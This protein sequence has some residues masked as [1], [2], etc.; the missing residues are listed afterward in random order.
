MNFPKRCSYACGSIKLVKIR[1][2]VETSNMFYKFHLLW[3]EKS[4]FWREIQQKKLVSFPYLM[5]VHLFIGMILY[6]LRSDGSVL[7]LEKNWKEG[8]LIDPPDL[9]NHYIISYSNFLA[10][11]DMSCSGIWLIRAQGLLT[12][13]CIFKKYIVFGT[14][15]RACSYRRV[16]Y[17]F[18][19][20]Y[21]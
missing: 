3:I 19:T 18:E 5:L 7:R 2:L 10:C 20:L 15:D 17:T 11:S 6:F 21:F 13:V 12:L 14:Y 1:N 16:S 8:I 9:I 4:C